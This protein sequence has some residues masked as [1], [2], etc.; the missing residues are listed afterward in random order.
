MI[1]YLILDVMAFFLIESFHRNLPVISFIKLCILQIL[2]LLK[3]FLITIQGTVYQICKYLLITM[4]KNHLYGIRLK[5]FKQVFH[6]F[7]Q[8]KSQCRDTHL[9]KLRTNTLGTESIE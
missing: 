1:S 4:I 8:G 3:N 2:S 6:Q 5:E 7:L 9:L